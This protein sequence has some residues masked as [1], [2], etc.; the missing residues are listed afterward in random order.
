MRYFIFFLAAFVVLTTN[1]RCKKDETQ[2]SPVELR[3]Q[4]ATPWAF[5]D[6]T[7]IPPAESQYNFGKIDT[8]VKTGYRTFI[9]LYRYAGINLIMNNKPY[10]LV[11]Y[12]YVSEKPLKK[13]KYTYKLTY[14]AT[15]DR[16]G[17]ELIKD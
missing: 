12:D 8:D 4:N 9:L 5:Y 11:P 15:D 13:G 16:L 10:S 17:L 2:N 6:C 14:I 7:V 3:I 1:I